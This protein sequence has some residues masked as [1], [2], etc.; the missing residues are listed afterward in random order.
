MFLVLD[1]DSAKLVRVNPGDLCGKYILELEPR[2]VK[3]IKAFKTSGDKASIKKLEKIIKELSAPPIPE[4][5]NPRPCSTNFLA[6]DPD[7]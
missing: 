7:V 2:V 3:E 1:L 4:L 5:P 6:I